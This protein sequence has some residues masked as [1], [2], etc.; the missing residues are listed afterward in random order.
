MA[1]TGVYEPLP[2]R[3]F[4]GFE[5]NNLA[6]NTDANGAIVWGYIG[7]PDMAQMIA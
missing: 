1:L 5:L 3:A 2:T 7:N 4:S 6:D